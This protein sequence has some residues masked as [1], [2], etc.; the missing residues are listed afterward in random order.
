MFVEICCIAVKRLWSVPPVKYLQGTV[1]L[2]SH[3]SLISCRAIFKKGDKTLKGEQSKEERM[4]LLEAWK[5]FEVSR[6]IHL[7]LHV[8]L[9]CKN[10]HHTSL[11]L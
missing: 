5:Q 3:L 9:I 7:K 10:I 6:N 11:W 1:L 4:M 8:K 2:F